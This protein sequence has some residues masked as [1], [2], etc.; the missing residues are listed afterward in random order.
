MTVTF[1]TPADSLD[2]VLIN[3]GVA[4]VDVRTADGITQALIE[5]TGPDHLIRDVRVETVRNLWVLDLPHATGSTVVSSGGSMVIGNNNGGTV[6]QAGTL[7][8]VAFGRTLVV[9]GDAHVVVGDQ[10]VSISI[11]VPRGTNLNTELTS[12]SVSTVHAQL[13]AV[14]HSGQSGDVTIG[15]VEEVSANTSSGDVS[16]RG[17]ETL[18]TVR[19]SSGD[20]DISGGTRADLQSSS[21]DVDFV[22]TRGC[23][24]DARTSSGDITVRRSGHQVDSR[25]RTSSGDVQDR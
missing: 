3:A 16:V 2:T 4:N 6:I 8:G 14:H 7:N 25:V 5:V 11:R 19:T 21:G 12:G 9:S 24:L 15:Y 20:I 1:T 13:G 17:V 23:R 18:A 10:S 22:A